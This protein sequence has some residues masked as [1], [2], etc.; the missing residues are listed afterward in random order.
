MLRLNKFQTLLAIFFIPRGMY[1]DECPF[2]SKDKK[3]S[4]RENGYCS[5]LGKGD[6]NLNNGI[7]GNSF[8]WD[9]IKECGMKYPSEIIPGAK[10]VFDNLYN[11]K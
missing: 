5:Y 8:L 4:R 7:P 11:E 6:W 1:C 10:E 9:Q 3:R 2:W